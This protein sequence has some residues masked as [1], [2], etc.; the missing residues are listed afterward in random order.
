MKLK[1]RNRIYIFLKMG[2]YHKNYY[3]E[4][5]EILKI[6]AKIRYH[7]KRKKILKYQKEYNFRNQEKIRQYY[8]AYYQFFKDKYSLYNKAYYNI[9]KNKIKFDKTIPTFEDFSFEREYKNITLFFD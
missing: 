9:N 8:K 2:E 5:K 7:K 3:K 4:N 1:L 6:K